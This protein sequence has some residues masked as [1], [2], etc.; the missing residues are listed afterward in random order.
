MTKITSDVHLIE[1]LDHPFPGLKIVPYLIEEAPNDLT[2]IDTCFS[3]ELPKLKSYIVNAGYDFKNIKRIILTHV[4]IDHIQ[5]ANELKRLS[6]AKLYSHW[7]EARYL[8]SNP[9]YQGPPNH[10]TVQ[11][12]LKKFGAK[13]ED[14]AKKFGQFNVDPIIVDELLQDGDMIRSLQV[15][16]TPGHTPGHLSLYSKKHKIIFGADSLFKS[17]LGIDGLFIPTEVAID[18]VTAAISVRRFSQV[19]FDKLLLSHQ[20]FPILEDAQKYVGRATSV[21]LQEP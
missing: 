17:V 6:G 8:A 19:K 1:N 11:K 4:H 12:L 18:S 5:A 13:M 3:S 20:D 10:E 7:V 14:I 2:L 21:S 16:H 9:H 15:I